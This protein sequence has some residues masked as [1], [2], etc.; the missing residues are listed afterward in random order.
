LIAAVRPKLRRA[1]RW[2]GS[3]SGTK[4]PEHFNSEGESF[5]RRARGRIT[6]I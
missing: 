1:F 3:M 2:S 5:L 4:G 6:G